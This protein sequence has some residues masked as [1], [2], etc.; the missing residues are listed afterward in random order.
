MARC[1]GSRGRGPPGALG[2]GISVL[3]TEHIKIY[4]GV[5]ALETE[6]LYDCPRAR[7]ATLSGG[8]QR[9]RE[10]VGGRE[11]QRQGSAEFRVRKNMAAHKHV[12][13]VFE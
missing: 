9:P 11:Q 2:A 8:P 12:L 10:R 6:G 4:I 5:I 13:C 7:R 3:I 1:T